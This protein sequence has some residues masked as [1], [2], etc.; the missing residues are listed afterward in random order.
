ML[1]Q[2]L[3]RIVASL[4]IALYKL[5]RM[6]QV[7]FILLCALIFS[8]EKEEGLQ[9]EKPL[10]HHYTG[11]WKTDFVT[12][13]GINATN[14]FKALLYLELDSTM[15]KRGKVSR[16]DIK[17]IY[18]ENEKSQYNFLLTYSLEG[19][20]VFYQEKP[21]RPWDA[22]ALTLKLYKHEPTSCA[23]SED[24]NCYT[25]VTLGLFPIKSSTEKVMIIETEKNNVKY[26]YR[27][28][29]Q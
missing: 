29:K 26:V 3:R 20:A 12:V 24:S 2:T 17:A 7:L 6:K 27:F 4:T 11:L 22:P 19:L 9:L 10:G 15:T 28:I 5:S 13:N 25:E 21:A 14:N 18:E 8:C 23:S 1:T 16:Y